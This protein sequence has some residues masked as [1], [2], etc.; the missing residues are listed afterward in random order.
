AFQVMGARP[1]AFAFMITIVHSMVLV[2]LVIALTRAILAPDGKGLRLP[3]LTDETAAYM[4]I[5][6]RRFVLV[7]LLGVIMVSTVRLPIDLTGLDGTALID[8]VRQVFALALTLLMLIFILQNRHSVAVALTRL[9]TDL[10]EQIPGRARLEKAA[11]HLAAMARIWH[12][13]TIVFLVAVWGAWAFH[14]DG[15]ALWLIRA[16]LLSLLILAVARLVARGIGR[17]GQRLFALTPEMKQRLPGLERRAGRYLSVFIG[18]LHLVVWIAATLLV[19]RVWGVDSFAWLGTDTGHALVERG[20]TVGV[21]LVLAFIIWE[22]VSNAI[23]RYL[24]N[25]GAERS[26]RTRTLLPLMRNAFMVLLVTIVSLIVLSEIGIDIAP[27]LAG[28]GVIGLAIGF[29]A[30]T[31]VKDVITGLFILIEDSI[32]VGDVASVGGHAGLVEAISIRTIRLRDLSGAV[33]TVPYSS[34]TTVQN[35][36]KGFSFYVFNI[37]VAYR[38]NVDN[39][40]AVMKD[41]G[42]DLRADVEFGPMILEDFEVLGLDDFA[43]SAIVIKARF[44]TKALKQWTVGREYNRRLKNRF[45]AEGIEIPFPHTTLYFGQDKDGKAPPANLAV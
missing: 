9:T 12:M 7:W 24:S 21:V 45:D 26:A 10:P 8:P 42:A 36:T 25:G 32:Q 35:L 34:V 29:G 41:V 3:K 44:K 11:G 31:L 15:G 27:L 22:T 19:L 16:A 17:I 43:D 40:M 37:G 6:V 30:Q 28:A 18:G 39:V 4:Q 2:G 14:V 1:E 13:P 33:H 23:E 5:W 38:E 20:L